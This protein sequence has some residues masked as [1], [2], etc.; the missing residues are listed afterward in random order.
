[1]PAHVWVRQCQALIGLARVPLWIG[2]GEVQS[3]APCV[4]MALVMTATRG[5]A[6]T[7]QAR[8]AKP[9]PV[10]AQAAESKKA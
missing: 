1:V 7:A 6:R 9:V 5:C 3:F 4:A 8:R 10:A 2:Q